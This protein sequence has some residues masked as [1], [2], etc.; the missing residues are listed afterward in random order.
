MSTI[1]LI[2]ELNQQ[3]LNLTINTPEGRPVSVRDIL[4]LLDQAENAVLGINLPAR[5]FAEP[6]PGPSSNRP[7][8]PPSEPNAHQLTKN[9]N[10]TGLPQS[11]PSRRSKKP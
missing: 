11:T 10:N 3:K 4:N 6:D 1:R 9:K 5:P 7:E 8:R 2:I